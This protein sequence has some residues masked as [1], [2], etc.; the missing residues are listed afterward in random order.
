ME[1]D[2]DV[3]IRALNGAIVALDER[4]EKLVQALKDIRA[5]KDNPCHIVNQVLGDSE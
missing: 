4:N 1:Y 3:I 5:G 2:K